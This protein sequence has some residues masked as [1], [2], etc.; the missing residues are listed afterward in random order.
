[1]VSSK[2]LNAEWIA[3]RS[4]KLSSIDGQIQLSEAQAKRLI[5]L[6]SDAEV[7]IQKQINAALQKGNSTRNL[8]SLKKNVAAIRTQ[9]LAGGRTWALDAIPALYK[10]G[11]S[12]VDADL[13][14]YGISRIAYGGI[15]QQA[16]QVLAD[17][18]YNR[19]VDVDA[20]IGRHVDD[21]YAEISIE[22][23]KGQVAGYNSWQTTAKNI[24]AALEAKGIDGFTDRA[25]RTWSLKRYTEMVARTTP[26]EALR[27]GTA[28]RILEHG[29]DLVRV[30]GGISS[31]TCAYCQKWTGQILSLTGRTSGYPTVSEVSS[32]GHLF[33]PNCAHNFS[34]YIE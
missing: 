33:G 23:A 3:K 13:A 2:E 24:R 15:H 21:I 6:Y 17:R 16:M 14:T 9:L 12:A 25:G 19:L 32:S 34:V 20:V 30:T 8:V 18:A 22:N 5:Q 4:A 10:V 26:R 31:K 7:Q 29:Y 28:M 27:Q 11:A 1:M